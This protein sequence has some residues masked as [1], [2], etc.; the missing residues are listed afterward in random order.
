MK[1]TRLRAPL[2][3][4]RRSADGLSI[5][6]AER[7]PATTSRFLRDN[8]PASSQQSPD[9]PT[10][11]ARLPH[12]ERATSPWRPHNNVFPPPLPQFQQSPL[13]ALAAHSAISA[14]PAVSPIP[15]PPPFLSIRNRRTSPGIGAG[16]STIRAMPLAACIWIFQT[17]Q[18]A[19]RVA[20]QKIFTRFC[21]NAQTRGGKKLRKKNTPIFG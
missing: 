12:G 14:L 5:P 16:Y 4:F 6:R 3:V 17:F 7:F 2:D 1:K 20:G 10:V 18:F 15:F 9:F 21:R 13:A 19:A 8:L 11:T